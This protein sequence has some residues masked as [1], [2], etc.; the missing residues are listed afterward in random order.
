MYNLVCIKVISPT[1]NLPKL[2]LTVS[3]I[4]RKVQE[5]KYYLFVFLFIPELKSEVT[6][7]YPLKSL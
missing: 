4:S 6:V 3:P 7:A 5:I 2:L 1:Y